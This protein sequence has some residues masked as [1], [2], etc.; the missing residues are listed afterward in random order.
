MSLPLSVASASSPAS[1]T[2][3]PGFV[4]SAVSVPESVASASVTGTSG[5][6]CTSAAS[7]PPSTASEPIS[8][9]ASCASVP[10][11]PMSWS[12]TSALESIASASSSVG[13]R[14]GLP[15]EMSVP[16][17][18]L[19][20]PAPLSAVA[21]IALSSSGLDFCCSRQPVPK[22]TAANAA[23]HRLIRRMAPSPVRVQ[24]TAQRG[25]PI[26]KNPCPNATLR[27]GLLQPFQATAKDYSTF[28]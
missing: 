17:S 1:S 8:S 21:A 15:I 11:G 23:R 16:P 25:E 7:L 18:T 3:V 28:L 13:A 24:P 12:A 5:S 20:S 10:S 4:V 22:N 19:P 14:S 2:S 9:P 27:S 26:V 6:T